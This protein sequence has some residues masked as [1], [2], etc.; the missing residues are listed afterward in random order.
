MGL[1]STMG[2]GLR[3]LSLH[4]SARHDP[5]RTAAVQEARLRRLLAHA[6][7]RSAF[8]RARYRG[9]DVSRCPLA[10][11]P[12][13][14]KAELM[15]QFDDV[16][17]DSRV[18][19]D[20]VGRFL[21]DPSNVGR[22]FHGRWAVSHTS[23]SQGQ[24]LVLVQEPSCLDL[25]FALQMGRGNA[26]TAVNAGEALRRLRR[27]A[28]LAVIL[29]KRGFYPTGSAFDQIG[30]SARGFLEVLRLAPTDTDLVDRLN[31][32][33]PNAIFGY[34]TVLETLSLA[35]DRLRLAPDLGQLTNSSEALTPRARARL[36]EA[37]GVPVLDTYGCGECLFLSNGCP[38][39][40]G[41]HVNADWAI[42]ENVDEA[43][44]PVPPGELGHKVLVTNLANAIQP[45][46]RYELGDRVTMADSPCDCGS[47]LPRVARVEGRTID[48][49]W[50]W[51]GLR[52]REVLGVVFE[53]AM[54]H[55]REVREW[56]AVQEARNRVRL[57]VLPLP[58][59]EIDE[60]KIRRMLDHQFRLFGLGD[61]IE[62]EVERVAVLRPDAGTG[63]FRRMVSH[64]GPPHSVEVRERMPVEVQ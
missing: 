23:G 56:Q 1:F 29:M 49:F 27:P 59:A 4:H 3:V 18:R 35:R 62:V 52:H 28:R 64:V 12:V 7:R 10:E 20:D 46:I 40:P 38:A 24:P 53:H 43:G 63:K 13:T 45:I 22:L 51:D 48:T 31:D 36:R 33:R 16:V 60:A 54:E 15:A 8:Y 19:L 5:R 9:L 2:F 39:G 57:R 26:C 34:A 21:D 42:L 14:T 6:V 61:L 41:A 58:R 50:V 30:E 32:F 47:R 17:T 55:A 37:F 11:L 44:R 25:L